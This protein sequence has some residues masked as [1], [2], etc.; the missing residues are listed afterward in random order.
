MTAAMTKPVESSEET[1][2]PSFETLVERL[3][4]IVESLESDELTLE[5]ALEAYQK[6]VALAKEGHTRLADAERKIEE[7]TRAG[8]VEPL[9]ASEILDEEP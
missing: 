4:N 6:G 7:L 2:P 8:T 3:E 9:E 1:P 5:E